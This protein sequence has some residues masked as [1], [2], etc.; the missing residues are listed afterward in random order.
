MPKSKYAAPV[1][2][3]VPPASEPLAPEVEEVVVKVKK[4]ETEE[5]MIARIMAGNGSSDE[6]VDKYKKAF[7]VPWR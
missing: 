6:Y 5:E 2:P 7:P 4:E 3:N 1:V